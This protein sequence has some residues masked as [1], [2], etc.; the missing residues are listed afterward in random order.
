MLYAYFAAVTKNRS[1]DEI[2]QM[3]GEKVKQL[4][5]GNPTQNKFDM[6]S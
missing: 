5:Y 3:T 6:T 2:A 1:L 4:S